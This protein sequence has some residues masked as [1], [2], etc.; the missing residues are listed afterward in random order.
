MKNFTLSIVAIFCLSLSQVMA[1]NPASNPIQTYGVYPS[2]ESIRVINDSKIIDEGTGEIRTVDVYSGGGSNN[3][4]FLAHHS[5]MAAPMNPVNINALIGG[6]GQYI[7]D[8][9][10][11][12]DGTHLVLLHSGT[13][14][15]SYSVIEIYPGTIAPTAIISQPLGAY[16]TPL[17]VE[18]DNDGNIIIAYTGGDYHKF[19]VFHSSSLAYSSPSALA[20]WFNS[21]LVSSGVSGTRG[22]FS[23]SSLEWDANVKKIHLVLRNSGLVQKSVLNMQLAPFSAFV[24]NVSAQSYPGFELAYNADR[25]LSSPEYYVPSGID[26]YLF[27]AR[28]GFDV[29]SFTDLGSYYLSGAQSLIKNTYALDYVPECKQYVLGWPSNLAGTISLNPDGSLITS[30]YNEIYMQLGYAPSPRA[31][32]LNSRMLRNTGE[33]NIIMSNAMSPQQPGPVGYK[34]TS[35]ANGLLWRQGAPEVSTENDAVYPNPVQNYLSIE[36]EEIDFNG[37]FKIIDIAGKVIM[38]TS[39]ASSISLEELN[40]GNYFI[41]LPKLDGSM[42]TK[43]ISKM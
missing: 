43:Q 42:E 34:G 18:A 4:M 39:G 26:D 7:H 1:Q 13:G 29:Y 19:T 24:T 40:P 20:E 28:T 17:G 9:A 2:S 5:N 6:P 32:S 37:V 33:L 36:G 38:E 25:G 11:S 31:M 14:Q 21:N 10:L 30:T 22:Y 41:Q 15:L 23:Y 16:L 3:D 27:I 35:C 12:L 8:I